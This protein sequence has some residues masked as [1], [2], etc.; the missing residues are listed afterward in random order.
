VAAAHVAEELAWSE[1]R[2]AETGRQAPDLPSL[3]C[4]DERLR[5]SRALSRR[6]SDNR[7]FSGHESLARVRCHV[8][9]AANSF[10]RSGRIE[11]PLDKLRP[12]IR[13]S[14]PGRNLGDENDP[15]ITHGI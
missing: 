15:A 8:A 9:C 7:T 14:V 6:I 10:S 2:L 3:R 1:A 11:E 13:Q 4:A 12:A 5:K